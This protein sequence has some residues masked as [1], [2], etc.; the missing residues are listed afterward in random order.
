MPGK[1]T[2]NALVR[3]FNLDVDDRSNSQQFDVT[4]YTPAGKIFAANGC[5][6][7]CFHQ[8]KGF[9]P[10]AVADFW[11]GIVTDINYGFDDCTATDCDTCTE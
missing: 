7:L 8:Y 10:A 2:F 5:H 11:N 9:G 6:C 4:L 1:P 3:S